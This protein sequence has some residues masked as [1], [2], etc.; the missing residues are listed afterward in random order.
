MASNKLTELG[1]RQAKP[2]EKQRKLFD[3]G[4]LYLLIHPNSSK[5]WRLKYRLFG[6]EKLYSLGVYPEVSLTEA[7]EERNRVRALI[8][9][10]IDPVESKRIKAQETESE[11]RNTFGV[12]AEEWMTRKSIEWSKQH[13]IDVRISL[14]LHLLPF[15]ADR[16][17]NL[18]NT[19][20]LLS[21]LRK[22]EEAGKYVSALRARQR[23]DAVF[24]YAIATSRCEN[25]PA[26]NLRGALTVPKKSNYKALDSSQI[27]IFI[28]KLETSNLRILTKL[29][30]KFMLM[31]CVRTQEL[32]NSE[33]SEFEFDD[34][35]PVWRIPA[36]RMK[37][38]AQHLVPLSTHSIE[39]LNQIKSYS[40]SVRYVFPHKYNP[41]KT[42][43]TQTLLSALT[44]SLGYSGKATVHGFRSTFSTVLNETGN[45]NPD[46]IERQLSHTNNN[47]VR[48][49]YNHAEYLAERRGM[50]QWWSDYI[51]KMMNAE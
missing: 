37:M 33:W 22:L 14:R 26:S 12:I 46:A 30:M 42:M 35:S 44:K 8:R 39:I 3:G 49:A 18:I 15:L 1:V 24:L 2:A 23:C 10:G 50:M 45:W 7:R 19:K 47:K 28:Q 48:D 5:Y 6:K 16:P 38:K 4:G 34:N 31:T 17:I 25:N 21:I 29:A 36:E 9:R 20:E 41:N 13:L 43:S 51:V 27:P 40:G 32:I 11:I